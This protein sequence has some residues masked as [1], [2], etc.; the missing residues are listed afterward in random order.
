MT[1][2]KTSP[3]HFSEKDIADVVIGYV[4][5][6]EGLKQLADRFGAT[7]RVIKRRLA[8]FEVR[9]RTTHEQRRCDTKHGRY[10]QADATRRAWKR[11]DY[12][13]D[14]VRTSRRKWFGYD[15][16]G[17][18]NPFFGRNHSANTRQVL[19]AHARER[20]IAGV[21]DYGEDW[22]EKLRRKIVERDSRHCQV[23]GAE[24][25]M[26]QVHHVDHDRTNNAES[27][28]LTICTTC[29]LAY[30][31]RRELEHEIRAAHALL[32]ERLVPPMPVSRC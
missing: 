23:C 32:L 10:S 5:R 13:T 11:G 18:R 14:A 28:L 22:T 15:R 27:N 16:H 2:S 20:A 19:R 29:H 6:E 3:R 1:M 26:L 30:H 24:D 12:N 31:G 8:E 4:F 7:P 21:G 25:G 9:I 17:A